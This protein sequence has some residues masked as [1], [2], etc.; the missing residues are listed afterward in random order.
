[1]GDKGRRSARALVGTAFAR[2]GEVE[3]ALGA[4]G[5]SGGNEERVEMCVFLPAFS[6]DLHLIKC[7]VVSI[8]RTLLSINRPEGAKE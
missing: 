6:P 2:A 3:G 4:L 8:V 7:R 5:L 1:M